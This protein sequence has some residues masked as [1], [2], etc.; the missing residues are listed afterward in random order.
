MEIIVAH[1]YGLLIGDALRE[2]VLG[3][4]EFLAGS[5]ERTAGS[6]INFVLKNNHMQALV[7]TQTGNFEY[8]D[9]EKPILQQGVSLLRIRRIGI[10]GTDLHAFEGMQPYFEY[11]RI[12]GQ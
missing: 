2:R 5:I 1:E 7:C 8:R 10:C 6:G 12:L 4:L 9:A 3:L 11:P